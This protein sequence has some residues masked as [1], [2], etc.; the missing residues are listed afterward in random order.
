M[1]QKP[2]APKIPKTDVHHG[3]SRTDNYA[4]LR[5]DNWQEVLRDPKVLNQDIR[6]HL[7]AENAYTLSRLTDTVELQDQLYKEMRGRIKEDDNSVPVKDGAYLYGAKFETGK[8]YAIHYRTHIANDKQEI[9]ID[10][11]QLAVGEKYFRIISLAHSPDHRFVAYGVDVKGS[12]KYT[13]KI[14]DTQT[15]DLLADQILET[16]GSITWAADSQTFFYVKVDDNHRPSEVYRH[17]LGNIDDTLT[18][19]EQDSGLFVNVGKVQDG[20]YIVINIADHESAELHIIDANSPAETP[21]LLLKRSNLHE[22]SVEHHSGNFYILSNFNDREDFAIFKCPVD[23]FTTDA[24]QEVIPH[25]AGT[26]IISCGVLKNWLI[27]LQRKDGLPSIQMLNFANGE[28]SQVS[29]DEEAYSLGLSLGMEF[30]TNDIRLTYS[31]PT[32]PAQTFDYNLNTKDRKLIKEQEIPSGHNITDYETKRLFATSHDGEQIPIT[33]LY[34]A[35]LVLDGKAPMLLYGYGSYGYSMPASFNSKMLSLVD[36]GFVYAIAHVRGGMEKGYNWYKSAKRET[37]ANSFKDFVSCAEHLI[38]LNY[39]SAGNI[40]AE[41]RSAGGLLMGAINNMSPELWGAVISEVPFVDTLTTMLDDTLPLTPPEWPEWGNPIADEQAYKNIESYSPY[42][43][44]SKKK[45][46]AVLA[47]GGLTDPRVTYWEP[48]KWVAKLR[49]FNTSDNDI[50]LYTE[51]EAGHGGASG[52]FESLK[53]DA[54]LYAFAIKAIG[55]HK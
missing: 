13:I 45:Y 14:I 23:N 50:L 30:D 9:L 31:S 22:Y 32:T 2:I 12:E 55:L 11:N 34:N 20:S 25:E 52:R 5:D 49:E 47:V 42:D 44:I 39:T 51:M 15:G 40:I 41:G 53:E 3:I 21:K 7:E 4:W 43:Q 54:R 38:Q 35:G 17:V 19:H 26:L 28:Q 46:P 29:F 37:K 8:E 36:R 33:L 16:T 10:G 6:T 24:W 48:A 27:W 1:T 18:Y